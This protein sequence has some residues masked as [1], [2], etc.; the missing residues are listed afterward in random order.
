MIDAVKHMARAHVGSLLVLDPERMP[1]GSG[2][3]DLIGRRTIPTA[4][5]AMVGIITE[6]GAMLAP[7]IQ[8]VC[9]SIVSCLRMDLPEKWYIPQSVTHR[10]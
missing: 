4:A 3:Q 10:S 1:N 7:M 9:R 2:D 6:R 5:R 8:S